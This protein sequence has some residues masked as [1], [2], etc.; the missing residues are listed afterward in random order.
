METRR[1]FLKKTGCSS[2]TTSS[3]KLLGKFEFWDDIIRPED[4]L[5]VRLYFINLKK[6][7]SRLIRIKKDRDSYI[8]VKLPQQHIAEQV[9]EYSFVVV[10]DLIVFPD[11]HN[12]HFSKSYISG[13]S[14]LTFRLPECKSS[15]PYSAAGLL[16]WNQ[17][18]LLTLDNLRSYPDEIP[19]ELQNKLPEDSTYPLIITKEMS[20][21]PHPLVVAKVGDSNI[22]VTIFELPYKMFLSPRSPFGKENKQIKYPYQFAKEN[23]VYKYI[24]NVRARTSLSEL[25]NNDLVFRQLGQNEELTNVSPTFKVVAYEESKEDVFFL[26]DPNKMHR[27]QI[28]RLSNLNEPKRDIE[29]DY[30]NIS[31]L[32]TTTFLNYY[33][34]NNPLENLEGNKPV[35]GWKQDI[36]L[37]RDN[38]VEIIIKAIDARSGLKLL[39]TEIAERRIEK[40]KSLLVYRK[41]FEYLE[42][43]KSYSQF[44]NLPFTKIIAL[45]KG[46]Y[47]IDGPL[48][49]KLGY[50]PRIESQES[51]DQNANNPRIKMPYRGIDKNGNWHDFEMELN[52]IP[53][54]DGRVWNI[55]NQVIA[56]TLHEFDPDNS[57]I[58][59]D[60]YSIAYTNNE[61]NRDDSQK[62]GEDKVQDDSQKQKNGTLVTDSFQ[63]FSYHNGDF[64]D[65]YPVIP[66]LKFSKVYIPQLGGIEP[67]PKAHFVAFSKSYIESNFKDGVDNENKIFLQIIN[68]FKNM[69]QEV[70]NVKKIVEKQKN[71]LSAFYSANDI[72]SE[73]KNVFT[74]NY[75]NIG[76]LIN[77]DIVISELSTL[78]QGI[79]LTEKIQDLRKI[80]P[81]DIL[82]GLDSKILGCIDLK[83]ILMEFLPAKETPIFKVIDQAREGFTIIQEYKAVY[84]RKLNGLKSLKDSLPQ[85]EKRLRNSVTS[86]VKEYSDRYLDIKTREI[87]KEIRD[88][89]YLSKEKLYSYLLSRLEDIN[90]KIYKEVNKNEY[91]QFKEFTEK[92]KGFTS[93]YIS[94]INDVKTVIKEIETKSLNK[95]KAVSAIT[96]AVD[97]EARKKA[98]VQLKKIE[99]Q[100]EE[101]RENEN[102]ILG[103]AN[104]IV[105]R[106]RITFNQQQKHFTQQIKQLEINEYEEHYRTY[107]AI[108]GKI[109]ID[110][111]NN[112]IKKKTESFK[113]LRDLLNEIQTSAQDDLYLL[114]NK[115][116]D[117]VHRYTRFF[118]QKL[119]KH[120][121]KEIDY[122]ERLKEDVDDFKKYMKN[123]TLNDYRDYYL[124]AESYYEQT[125]AVYLE[126]ESLH[127]HYKSLNPQDLKNWKDLKE[128][129]EILN[130]GIKRKIEEIKKEAPSFRIPDSFNFAQ[131]IHEIENFAKDIK[132]ARNEIN[133]VIDNYSYQLKNEIED[134]KKEIKSLENDLKNFFKDKLDNVEK[135]LRESNKDLI[136]AYKQGEDR[137]R[138]VNAE[139]DR[140]RGILNKLRAID[141]KEMTYTWETDRFKD[142]NLG[143]V[144][145]LKGQDQP[146][147]LSVDI[148][149]TLRFNIKSFP[150]KFN[151]METFSYSKLSNF[152]IN[153]LKL[154]TVEFDNISFEAGSAVKEKFDVAVRNVKFQGPLNFVGILQQYLKSLDK[155]LRLDISAQGAVLGYDMPLP[156]V[157]GG[158][159]NFINIKLSM[160][161]L[162]PFKANVPMRFIFGFNNPQDKFLISVGIFGGRGCFQLEV[163]PERGIVAIVLVLEFGGVLFLGLGAAKGYAYLFA[164]IYIRKEKGGEVTLRGY[165]VCGGVLDILGIITVSMTF[166]MGLESKGEYL[167]GSC[168]LTYTIKICKFIKKSI[169]VTIEKRIHGAPGKSGGNGQKRLT[170]RSEGKN[171]EFRDD[172]DLDGLEVAD[173]KW[174]ELMASYY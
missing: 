171:E 141:K 60:K 92:I 8:V 5:H 2:Y 39:V 108:F 56:T 47:F 15:I 83:K 85:L 93:D 106:F 33:N 158:T 66:N 96:K 115:S 11:D 40:G 28:A 69:N 103:H 20:N 45:K 7:G 21:I 101:L 119:D 168:S 117:E 155:G 126:Y 80:P 81:L 54:K 72:K 42:K 64:K 22:P 135:K 25:W 162:L 94:K 114:L 3:N 109:I 89:I 129:Q 10:N 57:E 100:I 6:H 130:K 160:T 122:L 62:E 91:V 30:F 84:E 26:P 55:D 12:K 153:V 123:K 144:S 63:L 139:I 138:Q 172:W 157:T 27:S 38:Y 107:K 78:K 23:T 142:A 86:K 79:T 134:T 118:F 71:A 61:N 37:G 14:Y 65:T 70:F 166:N 170:D 147:K 165:V 151:G 131:E 16:N 9:Q 102:V 87:Y 75:K 35:H 111:Y 88:T 169:T 152:S 51:K 133:K 44:N 148:K 127:N 4:L 77:P 120:I 121:T 82:R 104:D 97:E 95:A 136:E 143:I 156:D 125:R 149:N 164:G 13:F 140:L 90:N 34:L 1:T 113:T 110:F 29:S 76:S 124:K 53:E 48:Y 58:E 31:S 41:Y 154:I 17:F 167:K 36:A 74:E 132:K 146:T 128:F 59:V 19:Q 173:E 67:I 32:G 18:E 46:S 68:K 163:E 145:F 174:D 99:K 150:P 112:D 98:E 105:K 52:V 24:D 116:Y 73:I 49:N 159:F 50:I 43:E 137:I 161:M